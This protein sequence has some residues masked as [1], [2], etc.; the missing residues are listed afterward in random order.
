MSIYDEIAR[1]GALQS[2][3][4]PLRRLRNDAMVNW[5]R[6]HSPALEALRLAGI[7]SDPLG[8]RGLH[9]ALSDIFPSFSFGS[10]IPDRIG[11]ALAQLEEMKSRLGF[12]LP[13]TVQ[14]AQQLMDT[15]H[16]AT[17]WLNPLHSFDSTRNLAANIGS[18]RA[19]LGDLEQY[20]SLTALADPKRMFGE[21]A[22]T[23]DGTTWQA[24]RQIQEML[25]MLRNA[26]IEENYTEQ[27]SDDL[28]IEDGDVARVSDQVNLPQAYTISPESISQLVRE[29]IGAY[30][31]LPSVRDKKIFSTYL[32][33]L[34]LALIFSAFNPY[35]DF[36][37]KQRLESANAS[38]AKAVRAAAQESG[39]PSHVLE[40]FRFVS[41]QRLIVRKNGKMNS[42]SI[43]VLSFGQPIEVLKKTGNWTLVHYTDS[44]NEV[45]VQ[46]WVLSRYLK[47]YK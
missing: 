33:P 38:N 19:L 24:G 2:Q 26:G 3:I 1:L 36:L 18:A 9:G 7:T 30:E 32:F 39:V 20:Q 16:R 37:I 6:E 23:V 27:D 44:A 41:T 8:L 17:A 42:P 22:G 31:Q 40:N 13:S 29:W 45:V 28:Q 43:A 4:E 12:G 21:F 14:H 15:Y 5:H 11:S 47:R 34:I 46:G 35:S 10:A 25:E